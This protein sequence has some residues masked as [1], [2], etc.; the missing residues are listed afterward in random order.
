MYIQIF[1]K[2]LFLATNYRRAQRPEIL[3]LGVADKCNTR[4]KAYIS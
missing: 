2:I 3:R 1:E 4:K